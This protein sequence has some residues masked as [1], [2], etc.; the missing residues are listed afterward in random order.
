VQQEGNA[1]QRL[2]T[3]ESEDNESASLFGKTAPKE[4]LYGQQ[5]HHSPGKQL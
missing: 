5:Q 2:G 3:D 4:A 1:E